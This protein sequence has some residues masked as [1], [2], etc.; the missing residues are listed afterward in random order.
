MARK[1]LSPCLPPTP[2]YF[3]ILG[4]WRHHMLLT[5]L[6]LLRVAVGRFVCEYL[7]ALILQQTVV[8]C[9]ERRLHWEG[10]SMCTA[11]WWCVSCQCNG[12]SDLC[13][14]D[15][16]DNCDCK[17]NTKSPRCESTEANKTPCWKFQVHNSSSLTL[18][19]VWLICGCSLI[20]PDLTYAC[21]LPADKSHV[22]FVFCCCLR[23]PAGVLKP[24]VCTSDSRCLL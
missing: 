16:G 4:R 3:L 19:I 11:M 21:L 12:H 13:D 1:C 2:L 10:N 18:Y 5:A 14:K 8:C 7:S 24:A 9:N 20:M 22:G 17:N 6:T 23:L 15:R